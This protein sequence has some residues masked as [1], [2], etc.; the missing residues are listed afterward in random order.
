MESVG[1]LSPQLP[2]DPGSP[3]NSSE[4]WKNEDPSPPCPFPATATVTQIQTPAM[5]RQIFRQTS[6]GYLS[7]PEELDQVMQVTR[8]AAWIALLA[9]FV[10]VIGGLVWSFIATVPVK[11]SG[12]GI[13]ISPGGVLDVVSAS[14]GRVERFLVQ[15]GDWVE[16][17]N[18]VAYLSQPDMLNRLDQAKAELAEAQSQYEKI[19][20]F[21]QRDI[22]L[23]KGYFTQKREVLRQQM[24]FLDDRLRWLQERSAIEI[25]LNT[26]GLIERRRLVDTKI[27]IN[28]TKEEYARSQNEIK[29]LDLDESTLD[30]SKEKERI[31]QQLKISDLKRKSDALSDALKR[32]QELVSPYSGHIVEFHVNAGEVIESGRSLFSMLPQTS[33]ANADGR[34]SRRVG[35]L[36]AKIYVRPE[37]G[38]KIQ[39]GMTAEIAPSTIKRE[40]YGFIQGVVSSVAPIPSTE[41]GM[42]RTLKNRQ[43]VQELSGGGAPFEISVDLTVSPVTPSGFQW[44][45][46][47]GPEVEINPGTLAEGNVKVRQVHMISLLIP[48]LERILDHVQP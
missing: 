36:V 47:M 27:E 48:A 45:S 12:R 28:N 41:D 30:I 7:T 15:S 38:K 26:K 18:V 22:A 6:I 39:V 46:S 37:D 3:L 19:M 11:V 35:D 20:E 24:G 2:S 31:D 10:L 25:E 1:N 29:R 9:F 32:N 21:Q 17:G 4:A 23:Q 8:P 34:P 33:K 40:E 43:L 16:A 42:L 13:L 5:N 44:S 14:G